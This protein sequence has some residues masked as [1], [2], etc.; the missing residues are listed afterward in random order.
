M[1]GDFGR[2][3]FRSYRTAT[4]STPT[5]GSMG[6]LVLSIIGAFAE[7]E[8]ELISERIREGMARAAAE[9]KPIGQRGPDRRPRWRRGRRLAT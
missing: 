6:R 4:M 1:V 5:G 9:G 3:A 8:R 2:L 7:F